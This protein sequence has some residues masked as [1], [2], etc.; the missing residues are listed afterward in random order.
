M[1]TEIQILEGQKDVSSL[2]GDHIKKKTFLNLLFFS[3]ESP[4]LTFDPDLNG[5]SSSPRGD[6][7]TPSQHQ[8]Q[9]ASTPP[10]SRV[11]VPH[12]RYLESAAHGGPDDSL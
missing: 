7:V 1:M 3:D 6:V 2:R 10:A 4:S 8:L 5:S 11:Q 9:R 12:S